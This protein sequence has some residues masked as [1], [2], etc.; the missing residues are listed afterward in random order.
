MAQEEVRHPNVVDIIRA[1]PEKGYIML[2]F[3]HTSLRE[4][5]KHLD[6]DSP[7][8]TEASIDIIKGCLSGLKA[9]HDRNIVHG[10]IKPANIL[11][12]E[13]DV[14]KISDFGVASILHKKKFPIPFFHGSRCWAAPEILKGEAPS[15]QSDLF[16]LGIICYLLLAKKHPF[17]PGDPCCLW[18]PEDLIED[19]EFTPVQI[20]DIT[21]GIPE[22]VGGIVTKLLHRELAKRFANIEEVQIAFTQLEAPTPKDKSVPSDAPIEAANEIA[23]AILEAKRLYFVQYSPLAGL[24]LLEKVIEKYKNQKIRYLA[25]AC[26]FKAFLHN[27]LREWQSA[28]DSASL[29]IEL[30]PNHLESYQTRG[31]ARMHRWLDTQDAQSLSNAREDFNRALLLTADIRKR[32]QIQKYLEQL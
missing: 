9:I 13:Q 14:P 17:N 19:Q 2:E 30:D 12:T 25:D 3:M 4:K 28:D 32:S 5:I 31:Y 27:F 26:S 29:G 15:Y 10:D 24:A 1:E 7:L 20:S 11:M 8:S 23:Q 6:E 18:E 22:E 16:S 21:K